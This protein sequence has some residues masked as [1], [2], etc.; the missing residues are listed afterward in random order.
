MGI[1]VRG[2]VDAPNKTKVRKANGGWEEAL[3]EPTLGYPTGFTSP[4]FEVGVVS[5]APWL[6]RPNGLVMGG[7]L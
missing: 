2:R 4:D 1:T 7:H 3:T 6:V 5:A